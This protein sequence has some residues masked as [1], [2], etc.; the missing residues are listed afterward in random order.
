MAKIK[1]KNHLKSLIKR[2]SHAVKMAVV[3]HK[4]NDYRPH[5]IRKYGMA[6][7][8]FLVIFLQ[9]GY[10]LTTVGKVL[11]VES[12]I[13]IA[14]LLEQTNQARAEAGVKPLALSNKL[15]EAATLKAQDML[16]NQYWAHTSP[17]G[18]APWYWFNEVDYNYAEAGENLA[19]G[20]Y[21]TNAVMMAWISSPDHNVNIIN[22]NYNEVGFAVISGEFEGKTTSLIVAHY[23]VEATDIISDIKSAFS[24]PESGGGIGV[25]SQFAI[26]LQSITPAGIV[27][28]ALIGLV[29]ITSAYAHAHHDKISKAINKSFKRHHG[30]YKAV[31]MGLLGLAV[32]WLY[33]GGQ[34]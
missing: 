21:S 22:P 1:N 30:L 17:E 4:K 14:S 28:L 26:A 8:I 16:T 18:V 11:G 19:K 31:G 5:L 2:T 27:A 23:G 3:P 33:G 10:N 9:I 34:I 29:I 32:I 7:V 13:T 25:L 20:F 24:Q 6:I 12:D 15:N